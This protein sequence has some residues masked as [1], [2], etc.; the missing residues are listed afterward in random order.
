MSKYNKT[1][2]N[3]LSHHAR[4]RL[5]QRGIPIECV[6]LSRYYT[7]Q[8]R[9]KVAVTV[10][11]AML[12]HWHT[13]GKLSYRPKFTKVL[14]LIFQG[15]CLVTGSDHPFQSIDVQQVKHL[16]GPRDGN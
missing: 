12:K 3:Y 11:P 2:Q 10:F 13:L 16:V 7:K 8:F 4:L 1:T 9:G 6:D 15:P 14:I 5:I